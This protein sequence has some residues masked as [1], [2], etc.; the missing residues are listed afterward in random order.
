MMKQQS[1]GAGRG[2]REAILQC[3]TSLQQ[4]LIPKGKK[5][6]PNSMVVVVEDLLGGLKLGSGP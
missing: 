2:E 3:I 1:R 6:R 4:S 5:N